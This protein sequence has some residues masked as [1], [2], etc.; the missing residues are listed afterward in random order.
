MMFNQH[1]GYEYLSHR[2]VLQFVAHCIDDDYIRTISRWSINNGNKALLNDHFSRGQILSK[3]WMVDQLKMLFPQNS[4]GTIAHY[5]GWY[6]TIA[7]HLFQHY[8]N[9]VLCFL[10]LKLLFC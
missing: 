3:L 1:T 4:L 6:A 10:F 2:K 5:G 9:L 7:Q 8:L